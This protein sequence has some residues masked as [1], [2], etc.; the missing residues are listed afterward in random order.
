MNADELRIPIESTDSL[1][2]RLHRGAFFCREP[3]C[4]CSLLI[5]RN[6]GSP[7]I[8]SSEAFSTSPHRAFLIAAS[9]VGAS[10]YISRSETVR[11]LTMNFG[12]V[13]PSLTMTSEQGG[14]T[15]AP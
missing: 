15:D 5:T 11:R 6:V 3:H 8:L 14:A 9:A 7:T 1:G 13:Q 12:T 4:Y 10:T 2:V